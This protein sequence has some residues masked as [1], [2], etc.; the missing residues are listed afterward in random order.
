MWGVPSRHLIISKTTL[1][2]KHLGVIITII[3]IHHY[4]CKRNLHEIANMETLSM[5]IKDRQQTASKVSEFES[6]P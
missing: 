6:C 1:S 4:K 3:I 5:I 2:S